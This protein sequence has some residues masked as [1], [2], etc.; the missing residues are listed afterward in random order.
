MKLAYILALEDGNEDEWRSAHLTLESA[1]AMA[2]IKTFEFAGL[3]PEE[4]A[5]FP[6]FD[7]DPVG[8]DTIMCTV[9]IDAAEDAEGMET[10]EEG[11]AGDWVIEAIPLED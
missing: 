3:S 9:E 8:D 7:W 2:R 5:E 4:Q 11:W 6:P 10:L 1:Q